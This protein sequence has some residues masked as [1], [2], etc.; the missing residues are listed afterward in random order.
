MNFNVS[1]HVPLAVTSSNDSII[2]VATNTCSG[3]GTMFKT[4]SIETDSDD[5]LNI[6]VYPNPF[7][8]N[9]TIEFS[10]SIE[11]GTVELID[12]TGRIVKSQVVNND[13]KLIIDASRIAPAVYILQIRTPDGK[14]CRHNL[15]KAGF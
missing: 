5:V 7:S 11:K 4:S 3:T 1:S 12:I 9:F 8:E 15:I 14:I 6:K 13:M 2:G 10:K